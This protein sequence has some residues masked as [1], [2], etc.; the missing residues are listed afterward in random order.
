MKTLLKVVLLAVGFATLPAIARADCPSGLPP[1][2]EFTSG[3]GTTFLHL[4]ITENGNVGLFESPAGIHNIGPDKF[5][6]YEG[7]GFCD[8]VNLFQGVPYGDYL[9]VGGQDFQNSTTRQPNGPGT[10]PLIITRR[11]TNGVWTL[12]Q[13]FSTDTSFLPFLTI[14]MTLRNNTTT[15]RFANLLRMAEVSVDRPY[16]DPGSWFEH[17]NNSVL[18]FT[19]V[20]DPNFPGSQLKKGDY[21]FIVQTP[22]SSPIAHRI[23]LVEGDSSRAPDPCNPLFDAWPPT[24]YGDWAIINAFGQNVPAHKSISMTVVYKT[25]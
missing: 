20:P 1:A 11:T 9:R 15:A 17:T 21:G 3:S 10:F 5:L 19:Y 8:F 6:P 2:L 16:G 12:T 4:C 22:G 7:Y 24:H 25:M 13:T 14:K 18:A 23:R